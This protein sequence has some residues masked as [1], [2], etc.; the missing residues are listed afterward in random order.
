[1][2]CWYMNGAGNDFMVVDARGKEMDYPKAAVELCKLTGAD[3]FLAIGDSDKS[4]FRFHFYNS[5]GSRAA[6]CG[7]ASRCVCRFAYE[8]GIS[9][10]RTVFETDAGLVR[11]ERVSQEIYRVWLNPPATL[12]PEKLPGVSYAV[13]GVPHAVVELPELTWQM[14]DGLR[15]RAK[16]LRFDPA[17]P[18]GA[19]V[20]F[21]SRLDRDTVRVLTYERGVENYTL[22]CGTGCGAVAGLLWAKG[23]LGTGKTLTLENRG[24][25]LQY[26]VQAENGH[27]TALIMDGPTELVRVFT[28]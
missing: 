25:T 20:T 1:M 17:F 21:F 24:G 4:D 22:A 5:D 13:V 12:E 18:E 7:N 8:N 6:L 27:I 19:N 3:G 23:A 28:V 14:A 11:G 10:E 9:E 16:S 26:R 15:E 2:K